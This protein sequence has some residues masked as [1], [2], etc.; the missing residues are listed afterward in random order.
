MKSATA[1]LIQKGAS[2]GKKFS[3]ADASFAQA[4]SFCGSMNINVEEKA[5]E[6]KIKVSRADPIV[7]ETKGGTHHLNFLKKWNT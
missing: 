3:R 7:D 2:I 1:M 6:K 4:T 5:I